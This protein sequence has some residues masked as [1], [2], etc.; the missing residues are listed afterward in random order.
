MEQK[1]GGT[2]EPKRIEE[3]DLAK[4]S[5]IHCQKYLSGLEFRERRRFPII[6]I[7]EL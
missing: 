4:E 1:S 7:R 3:L 5:E 6:K 2:K